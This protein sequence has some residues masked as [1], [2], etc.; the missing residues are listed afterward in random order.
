M[1]VVYIRKEGFNTNERLRQ[2]YYVSVA[3]EYVCGWRRRRR[4]T[5]RRESVKGM[6]GKSRKVFAFDLKIKM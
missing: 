5:T 6:G 2:G 4:T 1:T 3:D